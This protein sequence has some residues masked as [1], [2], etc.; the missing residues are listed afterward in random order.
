MSVLTLRPGLISWQKRFAV[1]QPE[2][3]ISVG[4]TEQHP[5]F[6]AG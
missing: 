3:S 1:V 2:H 6:G 5:A 4:M